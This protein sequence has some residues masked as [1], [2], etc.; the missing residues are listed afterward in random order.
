MASWPGVR[1]LPPSLLEDRCLLESPSCVA[2][3]R[4]SM[5]CEPCLRRDVM[6]EKRRGERVF[7][8]GGGKL[9]K[10]KTLLARRADPPF[11]PLDRVQRRPPGR[12]AGSLLPSSR[13]AAVM[14]CQQLP[15]C[16]HIIHSEMH[17]D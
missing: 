14:C 9:K 15:F 1:T 7:I 13:I 2:S 8:G 11:C 16:D 10:T 17:Y 4:P 6:A 3:T 12:R 5:T